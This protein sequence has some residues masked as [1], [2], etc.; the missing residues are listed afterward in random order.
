MLRRPL[1]RRATAARGPPE[2]G[3]GVLGRVGDPVGGVA[4]CPGVGVGVVGR[5]ADVGQLAAVGRRRQLGRVVQLARA[6]DL[7]QQGR[8]G[9]RHAAD[10]ARPPQQQGVR[11]PDLDRRRRG[12]VDAQPGDGLG[13]PPR[14]A[15]LL[16][17]RG[18]HVDALEVRQALVR[19][20]DAV[21]HAQRPVAPHPL[22]RRE[23]RVQAEV[24]VHPHR[25]AGRQRQRRPGV[26]VQ[27]VADRDDGVE[28]VVSALKL[29]QHQ[30]AVSVERGQA[31]HQAGVLT[32]AERRRVRRARPEQDRGAGRRQPRPHQEVAPSPGVVV[33]VVCGARARGRPR[34]CGSGTW[35]VS[36]GR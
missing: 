1:T 24:V 27:V 17:R 22:E 36:V 19:V 7:V 26:V 35:L 29:D 5:P 8:V 20:A 30:H 9:Q 10:L 25:R 12:G 14:R 18:P 13:R 4:Q 23:R 6:H 11:G 16:A 3:V 28:P 2:R 33:V 15:V 21:D 31:A 34:G 32:R